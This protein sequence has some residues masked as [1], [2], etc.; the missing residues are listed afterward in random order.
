MRT[1][2]T[3][4]YTNV[5]SAVRSLTAEDRKKLVA[6]LNREQMLDALRQI[7]AVEEEMPIEDI[8][9]E[10]KQYRKEKN[11]KEGRS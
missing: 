2:Q 7:P 8:V 4:S 10:I 9:A 3:S 6:E 1:R 11:G 5:L